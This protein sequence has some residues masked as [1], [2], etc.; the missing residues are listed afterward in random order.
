MTGTQSH[1]FVDV[2]VE[3]TLP[4]DEDKDP[5]RVSIV[6]D[7][8][9]SENCAKYFA[10]DCETVSEYLISNGFMNAFPG[11]EFYSISANS[12]G[13]TPIGSTTLSSSMSKC[14]LYVMPIV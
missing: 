13:S 8:Q 10:E 9:T 3:L 5:M 7:F 14:P 12:I 11:R 4:V 1:Y 6:C 2:T